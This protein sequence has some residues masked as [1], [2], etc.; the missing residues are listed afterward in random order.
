MKLQ[1]ILEFACDSV[2]Y[3]TPRHDTSVPIWQAIDSTLCLMPSEIQDGDNRAVINGARV[4]MDMGM[5][6]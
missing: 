6:G 5:N 2:I 4:A 1:Y 3:N